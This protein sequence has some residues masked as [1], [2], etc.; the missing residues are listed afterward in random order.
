MNPIV[1]N[2]KGQFRTTDFVGYLPAFLQSEPDV[3]TL[4]Q[5]M[6]DYINNAYRNIEVSEEFEFMVICTES[7][8][9]ATR[10]MMERLHDMFELASDRSDKVMYLSVPHNNVK[11]NSVLGNRGAE[12]TSG[13]E[14]NEPQ[15]L[16]QIPNALSRGVDSS[17]SDGSVVYVTYR[18][19]NP[20]KTVSYYLD[21][22]SNVLIK[23][24]MGTSQDPFT[25]SDNAENRAIEFSVS[26]VGKVCKRYGQKVGA[27]TYYEVFFT[28]KITDVKSV[29]ARAKANIDVD[30]TDGVDDT[31]VVDYYNIGISGID[32]Y[33]TYI[34]FGGNDAFSWK[35]GFPTGI[36]YLRDSSSANLNALRQ[37]NTEKGQTIE[38]MPDM[39][40]SPSVDRYR[41]NSITDL[42]S[43]VYRLFLDAFPGIYSDALFYL[44]DH[45][46]GEI[47]ALMKMT[48]M[49]SEGWMDLGAYYVDLSMVTIGNGISNFADVFT[50]MDRLLL[51]SLPL[52][53]NKY[54]LDYSKTIPVIKWTNDS[55]VYDAS[56]NFGNN[57]DVILESVTLVPNKDLGDGKCSGYN[58]TL[59]DVPE[60][61]PY[62]GMYLYSP[63]WE[64]LGQTTGIT[65]MPEYGKMRQVKA[66]LGSGI[67]K[68]LVL[69]E[70]GPE[71]DKVCK[72]YEITSGMVLP[73][74][75]GEQ[76]GGYAVVLDNGDVTVGD[77]YIANYSDKTQGLCR[78]N[79]DGGVINDRHYYS[80]LGLDTEKMTK[81]KT[82]IP[83][84]HVVLDGK[85]NVSAF[86]YIRYDGN[87]LIAGVKQY[88]GEVFSTK[89][90]L[91]HD[92]D[93]TD[94]HVNV[95]LLNMI[96]DVEYVELDG[97]PWDEY[98][99]KEQYIGKYVCFDASP[100]TVR[101]ITNDG[102][103]ITDTLKHYAIKYKEVVN[104]FM[105]YYGSVTTLGYEERPNYS[106]DIKI[107]KMPLYIKKMTDTRL[108]Y[109]WKERQ[110][111]YYRDDLDVSNQDRAGFVEF[112][113]GNEDS[114][115]DVDLKSE[116][117]AY[118]AYP[119]MKYG[120]DQTYVIDIDDKVVALK[121]NDSTWTVTIKSSAHGIP[122][123]SMVT[124]KYMVDATENDPKSYLFNQSYIVVDAS[125]PDVITY[126][127]PDSDVLSGAYYA[128]DIGEVYA[129]YDRSPSYSVAEVNGYTLV[130][131]G[132][133]HSGEPSISDYIKPGI[134]Q[135]KLVG[136]NEKINGTYYNIN[137]TYEVTDANALSI[138]V[139]AS[140]W[141]EEYSMT[142]HEKIV[143]SLVEDEIVLVKDDSGEHIYRVTAGNWVE[144][145]NTSLVLPV[146]IYARQNLF[147]VSYTN[148]SL[149]VGKDRV[150]KRIVDNGYG[151]ADVLLQENVST[152]LSED[153]VGGRVLIRYTDQSVYNG[154]HTI[155]GYNGPSSFTIKI[156]PRN[157]KDLSETWENGEPVVNHDMTANIGMWY[158]YTLS[159][160]DWDKISNQST[161]ATT[162][163]VTGVDGETKKR[164]VTK[165]THGFSVG[166]WIIFDEDGTSIYDIANAPKTGKVLTYLIPNK[167]VRVI[168]YY[169]FVV[170]S[171]VS[172]NALYVYRGVITNDYVGNLRGVYSRN[173][174]IQNHD[175]ETEKV[176]YTFKKGD[177]VATM[178]Q[179]C[180]DENRA[181]R[182]SDSSVWIPLEKKRSM[183]IDQMGVDL[184]LNPL[185][186]ETDPTG[187]ETEYRYIV[188]SDAVARKES[189]DNRVFLVDAGNARNA[190]FEHQHLETLDT[191]QNVDLEYSS[192][193]D[194]GTVAPRD[195][196]SSDFRGVPDMTYPLVEKIERLAYLKDVNVIDF[197]LIGYLARY[198]G[199]DITSVADDIDESNVYRNREE[200]E[201]AIRETIE[202]LPQYYALG[203]TKPGLNMLMATFGLVGDLVTMWTNTANPYGELV[204]QDEVPDRI[205]N[206]HASGTSGSGMWV[207]T[208]HVSLD[209]PLNQNMPNVT[210]GTEDLARMREQIRV[211]KPINV[212][213]DQINIVYETIFDLSVSMVPVEASATSG[214]TIVL[215]MDTMAI[216]DVTTEDCYDDGDCAF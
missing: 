132:F 90:M 19:M 60:K 178:N 143:V 154:W 85:C 179:V 56:A 87:T 50:R 3:V 120:Y 183:K 44:S 159:K 33:Y 31:V 99:A 5:V 13:I 128:S 215:S 21:K 150:I 158:K 209:I 186:D 203:G 23:D 141:P 20:V 59:L 184:M 41:V 97:K 69:N 26:D 208:P 63:D 89:Y 199:Y 36:F 108:K 119:I 109:G 146:T 38:L 110:Y 185:Y 48:S 74:L 27:V 91:A 145:D 196:M 133:G 83:L 43:G 151:T 200:R 136:F 12:Y 58:L 1:Y 206:D 105:P 124:V 79:A 66:V 176:F 126:T 116:A 117:D 160:Y 175:G 62:V 49:S 51:L 81:A 152:E 17:L 29:P 96:S 11:T 173:L 10:K 71:T 32:N 210:I 181:W 188:Y 61:A 131:G 149:A 153:N 168:D 80:I 169:T 197:E 122:N 18:K 147:D 161:F 4:M 102:G 92:V 187:S 190:H 164:V 214:N 93:F 94:T 138:T 98:E 42:G 101:Y 139:A 213:F 165:Y 84:T 53:Y 34:K 55:L 118:I 194:Y 157:P 72:V 30:G 73:N 65:T 189:G 77:F 113:A 111:L 16:D 28:A 115:V 2:E 22:E 54:T 14:V 205:T 52:A 35:S 204:R 140:G 15:V 130:V 167:V 39:V 68:T 195:G 127:V 86:E 100:A 202:H 121:N 95:N 137:G 25:D 6:S 103:P 75:H 46:T 155:V 174:N 170:E 40:T 193:Y 211:F 191:T 47:L 57:T 207:P 112:Y 156:L 142:G 166:D 192:K 144:L 67:N 212:V 104:A 216:D 106:G 8:S 148:P 182:V 172:E 171:E 107:T 64:D 125:N 88:E 70:K 24:P 201:K 162:N 45:I 135:V 37:E 163:Q 76:Y 123:G 7:R 198:M 129:Y 9:Y 78:I 114:V 82:S 134:T 180:V 177:I